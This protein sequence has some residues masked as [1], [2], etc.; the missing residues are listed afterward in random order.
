[1]SHLLSYAKQKQ[2]K[3]ADKDSQPS[4]DAISVRKRR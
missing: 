4:I 3:S 1:V 2:P